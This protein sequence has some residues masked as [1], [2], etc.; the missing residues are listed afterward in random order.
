MP[1]WSNWVSWSWWN[2]VPAIY[3]PRP[4]YCQPIYYEPATD[5]MYWDQYPTWEP[6]PVVSSGT[7]V[8]VPLETVVQADVQLLAVRFVDAG[9]P[10]QNLGPRYRVWFVNN[11]ENILETPFNVTLVASNGAAIATDSPEAGV[12]VTSAKPGEIQS[13]DIRLPFASSQMNVDSEGRQIPFDHLHAIVDSNRELEEADEANNGVSIARAEVLPVDPAAFSTDSEQAVPGGVLNIAGEGFGPE[14]GEVMV[15]VDGQETE[16]VIEGWY[17]LG[18][19]IRVPNV[20]ATSEAQ[21]VVVR[22]DGAA[23]NPL[24]VSVVPDTLSAQQLPELPVP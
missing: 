22:G 16:A 24:T 15:V 6:L 4:I 1:Y 19:Q 7:W 21:V 3:D 8:D 17:D 11:N 14:P 9:H 13:V 10:E 20:A 5:W 2:T 18:I 23:A 12:R